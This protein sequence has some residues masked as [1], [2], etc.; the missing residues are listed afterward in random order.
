MCIYT[1]AT[2]FDLI[3]FRVICE[4]TR[5]VWI[6]LSKNNFVHVNRH[7]VLSK[8]GQL[9]IPIIILLV[10]R[11]SLFF[12]LFLYRGIFLLLLCTT[13]F[14]FAFAG[15]PA[16]IETN[17]SC[18]ITSKHTSIVHA[19]IIILCHTQHKRQ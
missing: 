9:Y 3:V 15:L 12:Y 5:A 16:A 1:S 19:A 13:F 17:S 6:F 2:A 14:S 11:F 4:C 10:V 8:L 7:L 18:H